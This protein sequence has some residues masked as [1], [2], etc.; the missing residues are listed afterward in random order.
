MPIQYYPDSIQKKNLNPIEKIQKKRT[1]LS[2][3]GRVDLA[4]SGV[5]H[6]FWAPFPNWLVH[7]VLLTF[8][9]TTAKDYSINK[10]VGRGFISKLNDLLWFRVDGAPSQAIY[11]DQGF[12]TG[13][14]LS[15]QIKAKLD[16]NQAFIDLSAAPFT[17]TWSNTTGKFSITPASGNV[18][19]L[20][21][22]TAIGMNRNS[23]AGMSIGFTADTAYTSPIVSDTGA[24]GLGN[25]IPLDS[26]TS[27]STQNIVVGVDSL[28]PDFDVDGGINITVSS[29]ATTLD[30]KITYEEYV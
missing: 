16:A 6:T 8:G 20:C 23:T 9:A 7:D 29:V 15:A 18:Q 5:D 12:Y 22:N 2:V 27:D 4:A 28:S 13:T 24:F 10:V 21:T 25:K 1:I 26:G 14:T 11:L 17:V 19:L 3:S 30:F